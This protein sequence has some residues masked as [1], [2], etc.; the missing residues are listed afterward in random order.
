MSCSHQTA[1]N[2]SLQG[3]S[4]QLVVQRLQAYHLSGSKALIEFVLASPHDKSVMILPILPTFPRDHMLVEPILWCSRS[5]RR[6]LAT[7]SGCIRVRYRHE[8]RIY[9]GMKH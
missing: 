6:D 9:T 7:S 2:H 4:G 5:A 8:H 1:T 3:N